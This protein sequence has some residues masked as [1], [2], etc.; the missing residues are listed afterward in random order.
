MNRLQSIRM[1][2]W[3]V[4][5]QIASLQ[6]PKHIETIFLLDSCPIEYRVPLVANTDKITLTILLSGGCE[7]VAGVSTLGG[8]S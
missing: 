6:Q 3:R 8:S 5:R 1:S 7:V 4:D 2:W